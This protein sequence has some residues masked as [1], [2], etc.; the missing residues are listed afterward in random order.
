MATRPGA[1]TVPL[2]SAL[3]RPSGVVSP[4]LPS[5]FEMDIDKTEQVR[6]RAAKTIRGLLHTV[7]KERQRDLGLFS[8]KK[9]E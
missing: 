5:P 3:V 2:C 7:Y 4:V 1:A 8:L 6:Q 9:R